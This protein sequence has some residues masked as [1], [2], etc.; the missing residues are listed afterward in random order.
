[1]WHLST[2]ANN[3][4]IAVYITVFDLRRGK[5]RCFIPFLVYALV[6]LSISGNLVTLDTLSPKSDSV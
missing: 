4:I 1:M 2:Q 3:G 5:R 6:Y